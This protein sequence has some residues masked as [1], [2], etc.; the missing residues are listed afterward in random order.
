MDIKTAKLGSPLHLPELQGFK[1]C[2]NPEV[3]FYM[4]LIRVADKIMVLSVVI[5][6]DC[7]LNKINIG[8]SL[9]Y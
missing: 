6:A 8:D 1:S 3:C 7:M 5:G 9:R 2:A 4:R